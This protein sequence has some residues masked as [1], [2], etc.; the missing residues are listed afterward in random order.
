MQ[1]G[2]RR[3]GGILAGFPEL[4]AE[5]QAF[6]ALRLLRRS[7]CP[8]CWTPF[9][10]DE[11]LWESA[12]ED[13]LGDPR[14]GPDQPRRFLPSRFNVDG[15]ALDARGLACHQLAC[16][17]CHL[18]VPHALLE[19]EPFFVSILGTPA[20][21]K[22]YFLTALTWELRRLLPL[23]FGLSFL[24][25]DTV[26]NRS[27]S[28]YE[29]SLFLNPR[30]DQLVP[31]GDLIRKTELQG[32]L[33]DSV[34]YGN[35]TVQ[36]PRPFLFTLQP[37]EHHP[38]AAAA[39]RLGRVCCLYDNAGEHFLAGQD[40]VGSPVTQHLAQSRFLLFLF[41]PTQDPRFRQACQDART[42]PAVTAS[43]RTGRQESVLL[44][45]ATRVRRYSGLPQNVKHK[46]PLIVI[47]TK[48]DVWV[49][50]LQ[51]RSTENPWVG[52]DSVCALHTD[53]I[54]KRSEDVRRLLMR[55]TPEVVTAAEGF[56]QQVIYVPV[57]A[58]GRLPEV[59][60]KTG[61]LAVRP[62]QL[63]PLWV[64]VPMLYGMHRCLPGLIGGVAQKGARP[65][66]PTRTAGIRSPAPETS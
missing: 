37:Q 38:A 53:W 41:D 2:R 34:M 23:H 47:V 35:Q 66:G 59:D 15:N 50:L 25:A 7:T 65:Q 33:Y 63:R 1:R 11:I 5:V 44:E 52:R 16:P 13:L 21:G 48:W 58:L 46:R 42:G 62:G 24:E 55:L 8:H 64:T 61:K 40:T 49:H 17:R 14:L 28:D 26:A 31:L 56:A 60:P 9:A 4:A 45:A 51:D 29:E 43:G 10:P 32:E 30:A 57:S 36:Y 39:E 22:S 6:V 18:P 20:C 27:L 54:E 3:L 19:M 12:H